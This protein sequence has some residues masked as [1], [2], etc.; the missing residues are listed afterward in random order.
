MLLQKKIDDYFIAHGCSIW[1]S[2]VPSQAPQ[3]A[4]EVDFL[5]LCT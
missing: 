3:E 1:Q 2:N 5:F 4:E